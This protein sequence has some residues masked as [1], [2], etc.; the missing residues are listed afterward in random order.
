MARTATQR[1]G[2][3]ALPTQHS[4]ELRKS[5]ITEDNPTTA[6][7]QLTPPPATQRV[8]PKDATI[9]EDDIRLRA[10]ELY[11][12]RGAIPGEEISDWLQA[13]RELLAD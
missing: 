8:E 13:E 11:L 1:Q 4:R 3:S 2:F 5:T 6:T 10:Y 12:E 7:D 9:T